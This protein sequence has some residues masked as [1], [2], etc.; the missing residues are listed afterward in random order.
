VAKLLPGGLSGGDL[1]GPL[2]RG[3]YTATRLAVGDGVGELLDPIAVR[4]VVGVTLPVGIEFIAVG[5]IVMGVPDSVSC[6]RRPAPPPCSRPLISSST[7]GATGRPGAS[8]GRDAR[9]KRVIRRI[10]ARQ[11]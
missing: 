6:C 11:N 7:H 1:P 4:V 9:R 10:T 8:A 2:D 5:A 3:V